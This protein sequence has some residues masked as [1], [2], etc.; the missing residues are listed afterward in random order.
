MAGTK[1]QGARIYYSNTGTAWVALTAGAYPTTGFTEVTRG[2]D[3]DPKPHEVEKNDN[4][5]LNDLAPV[6]EVILKPGS[7]TFTREKDNT[8][9]STLR[10]FC[11][12]TTLK[13]WHAVYVDGTAEQIASGYLTCTNAGK[14]TKGFANRV[15][16]T[17]EIIPIAVSTL[18]THA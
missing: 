5:C 13:Q 18:L 2:T 12:G 7:W 14:A 16:E 11:D 4:S 3:I 17:Y 9:S 8:L 6:P 1:S 10:G 15:S